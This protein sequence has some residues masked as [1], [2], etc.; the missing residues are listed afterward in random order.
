LSVAVAAL[1]ACPSVA[2]AATQAHEVVEGPVRLVPLG[3]EPVRVSG[4][5]PYFGVI[6]LESASDGL[7]VVDDLSLERYLL[8]LNEVPPDWPMEALRA[9]AVAARTYALWTLSQPR[10]GAA[11]L[12]GFDICASIEC[13]VFSGAS[14]L[15]HEDGARWMKAVNS[16]A[17]EVVVY[18]GRPILAR[19]HSTSG[20]MTLAN[21]E[22]FEG[23]ADLPYLQPVE[24]PTEDASP[25]YRWS[26]RF[27]LERLETALE[28]AGWWHR[29]RGRLRD[30]RTVPSRAGY[31]YPDVV[32]VGESTVRRTAEE[33]R[34]QLR[35]AAPRLWP[36]L[37]PSPWP[38]TS[39]R[40]P[41][42]LPSNRF[43][44][45]TVDSEVVVEGRGWGHGTGMSQWGAYGMARN[46]AGYEAILEHYYTGVSIGRTR[47]PRSI[48]VGVDWARASVDAFGSFRIVDG[49]GAVVVPRAIGAWSFAPD[50]SGTLSV[51]AP[52]RRSRPLE[53]QVVRAP[54]R[55]RTGGEAIIAVRVSTPARLSVASEGSEREFVTVG[56]GRGRVRWPAPSRPG[57]YVVRLRAT[58]AFERRTVSTEIVVV[59]ARERA[60][61]ATPVGG[62]GVLATVVVWV[63]AIGFL[64][65][66]AVGAWAF[67]GTMGR[68][69][70]R[71]PWRSR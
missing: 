56:A 15:D 39:G 47:S 35:D 2:F 45:S 9:Q 61:R 57:R 59:G 12:Y 16:T 6:V 20:G 32:F 46:G 48:E 34:S 58:S 7:V 53:V 70:R 29:S 21:S 64:G 37:Y 3:D 19:Y 49:D 24:S 38:T 23:A 33:L 22:A 36:E 4:L 50:A 28:D 27:T 62:G 8:G 40:L 52:R 42:T 68:W 31:H 67:V 30:V 60:G 44:I 18:R 65:L 63:A 13:Q 66:V 41:E 71:S 43:D 55:V 69:S 51:T 11:A 5:N 54:R 25:L 10:S 26:V 17:R 1:L 14:V